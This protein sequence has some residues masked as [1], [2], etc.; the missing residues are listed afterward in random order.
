[1][2]VLIVLGGLSTPMAAQQLMTPEERTALMEKM[3]NAKTPEERLLAQ[4]SDE[5]TADLPWSTSSSPTRTPRPGC[6]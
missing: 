1:M 3:R 4:A 5:P 6:A 2:V